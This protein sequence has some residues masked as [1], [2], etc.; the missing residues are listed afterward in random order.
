MK[1]NKMGFVKFLDS[2]HPVRMVALGYL[3]Y[4]MIGWLLL[5]LPF[6]HNGSAITPLDALFT[7]TSAVSTTGLA[8]ANI[9]HDFS[10]FGQIIILIL[11]QLGGI[12]YMTFGS[13]IILSRSTKL[14]NRRK[15]IGETV[16]SMP[17][18]FKIDKFIRSV[19]IFTA[20]SETVGA[21]SLYAIFASEGIDNPIWSA[22]FHS[23]SAFCTAGFSLFDNSFE[24]MRGNV[25]VNLILG[26]LSYLGAV[27]FIVFIDVW[28]RISGKVT[29]LTLT[30][31]IIIVTTFWLTVGAV[32]LF[33][34]AEPSIQ[35]LP[36][37]ERLT[38]SFFQVMTSITTVGFNTLPIAELSQA[39]LFLTI[40]LMVIGASPAGTGGGLK[41]TTLTALFGVTKSSL[42]GLRKVTFW[43]KEIPTVRIRIATASLGFYVIALILGGYFLALTED[44]PFKE[45]LFEVASAL[46]T[47][48]LSTGITA[49]LTPF[50]KFIII[51]LMFVGRLGPLAFGI[52]LFFP[53]QRETKQEEQEED[54]A[55]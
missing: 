53:S 42:L 3:S 28:R 8:T 16:F 41:T 35:T 7:S 31:R 18:E 25:P 44:A 32:L 24:G 29:K 45:I 17:K 30:S 21:I 14:S 38:A 15:Q 1:K 54:L 52:A 2:V 4:V 27:G 9:A 49:L 47:V 50:G 48:G 26:I 22:I 13:F 19:I 34:V 36:P 12:G 43:G 10:S 40:I 6:S 51:T 55:I 11:I 33:F 37:Y 39:S 23:I 5:S 20:I 46:G